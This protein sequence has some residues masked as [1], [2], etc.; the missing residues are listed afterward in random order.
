MAFFWGQFSGG[1]FSRCHREHNDSYL[2]H[3]V[4]E[5]K[6]FQILVNFKCNESTWNLNVSVCFFVF[7][8]K[9][10][11]GN[12][13]KILFTRRLKSDLQKKL[14]IKANS[15]SLFPPVLAKK[16]HQKMKKTC[17]RHLIFSWKQKFSACFFSFG[18]RTEKY[19]LR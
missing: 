10:L 3:S 1:Q 17:L 8:K 11:F 6:V 2:I 16:N 13:A 14:S 15:S 12:Y 5:A 4:V 7:L 9:G 18:V 19:I